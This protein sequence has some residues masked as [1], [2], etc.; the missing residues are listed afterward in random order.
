MTGA[1][2]ARIIK[3]RERGAAYSQISEVVYN[4]KNRKGD[5]WRVCRIF[6]AMMRV[7]NAKKSSMTVV[8]TTSAVGG[9]IAG[10]AITMIIRSI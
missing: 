5:V 9:M 2:I 6:E 1:E 7:Q 3:L 10:S 4:T 8:A